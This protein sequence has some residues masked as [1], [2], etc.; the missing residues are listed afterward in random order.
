V[1]NSLFCATSFGDRGRCPIR[2]ASKFPISIAIISFSAFSVLPAPQPDSLPPVLT[3]R[4][5]AVGIPGAGALSAV[6]TFHSGGPIHDKPA[7]RAFTQPGAVLD[8]ERILVASTSNFG[9]SLARAD[10]PPGAILSIDPRGTTPIMVSPEF[11]SEGGQSVSPG[12]RVM[13]FTAN[14]PLFLNGIYNPG[15]VTSSFP[16]LANPTGISINNGFGRIW[17]TS[18]PHGPEQAGIHS[19]VDPDGRPLDNA[20]NK[21]AG[22]V[23]TGAITNREPQLVPG[24]MATGALATA[25]LGKSPDGSGRAVFASLHADGSVVQLHVEDGV[26]G[27]SPAGTITPLTTRS[28]STRAGMV[29]NWVPNP[30]LYIA[31]PLGNTIVALSLRNDGRT[32]RVENVRRLKIEGLNAPVDLAP[33]IPE[34]VS[35]TFSSNTTLAGNADIYVVNRGNGTIVRVSQ[36][37]KVVAVRRLRLSGLPVFGTDRLNGIAVS[38]D[39]QRIWVTVSGRLPGYAEG[40]II[41]LPAFGA[42]S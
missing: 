20:P 1:V 18:M 24:S 16:P 40:A 35:P 28:Q 27:L 11:A 9:A 34:G 21:T 25:L 7:F 36:D 10:H 17:I 3:G 31:D 5:V 37:G 38:P 29:F 39:A 13:L 15:A 6:G 12:G 30:I 8:P 14:S 26:D 19:V 42:H 22:G 23:F 32:Y 33:A 41:E 2:K 4:L